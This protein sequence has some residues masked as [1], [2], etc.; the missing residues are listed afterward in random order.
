M[1]EDLKDS[2]K[3][4]KTPAECSD[5]C[6]KH[7][8]PVKTIETEEEFEKRV[9]QDLSECR[10][11]IAENTGIEPDSFFWPW[12]QCSETSISIAKKCGFKMLFTTEKDAVT[13]NTSPDRIPRVAAP[14]NFADFRKQ[15]GI[16]SN[17]LLRKIRKMF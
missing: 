8:S 14:A 1:S 5:L 9:T 3:K 2:L 4:A 16:Y 12:G 7:P 17:N 15:L 10:K 11:A 6:K 13:A